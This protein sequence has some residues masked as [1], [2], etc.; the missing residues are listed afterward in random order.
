[1]T[2]HFFAVPALSPQPA[3]DEFNQFCLTHRVVNI[4]RQFVCDSANSYWALCATVAPADA[5][6]PDALKS[7]DS[8]AKSNITS[9][10]VDYKTVLSEQDFAL[11]AEL[12][13]WRKGMADAEGIPVYALFTN[14]QLA[15]IVRRR[16][17]SLNALGSID[18]IGPSRVQ[19]YGAKL[20]IH[21]QA[22]QAELRN[23]DSHAIANAYLDNADRFLLN[24]AAVCAHVRYMDDIVWW[25]RS[26]Q[27]AT[28]TLQLL[29]DFVWQSRKLTIKSTVQIRQSHQGLCFCGFR[30]RQ[31]VILPSSRKLSRYRAGLRR[32]NTAL[33]DA[34]VS[35]Q[36]SQRAYDNLLATLNATQSLTFRKRLLGND[37]TEIDLYNVGSGCRS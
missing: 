10:R 37:D 30:V 2:L 11:Y 8:R 18:G 36:H 32:I 29:R 26:R 3:Q 4:E 33:A 5:T 13:N 25:C 22:A 28:E 15:E 21:F 6:L 16:V 1:M 7:P 27:D 9:G 14:E 20:L 19:R 35:E 31:G 23:E 17:D 34:A 12:R 24:H